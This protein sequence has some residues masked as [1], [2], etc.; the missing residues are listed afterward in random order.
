[1][2]IPQSWHSDVKRWGVIGRVHILLMDKLRR[3]LIIFGVYVRPI[4][5]DAPVPKAPD[6]LLVRAAHEEELRQAAKDPELD[7]S[8]DFVNAALARGDLCTAAFDGARIVAYIW[9]SFATAPHVDGLWVRF[10]PGYRYGY[11][12][13]TLPAYRGRHLPACMAT[14]LDRYSVE[15]GVTRTIGSIETHNYPSIASELRRGS[16]RVGWAGYFKLFGRTYPF[17]TPGAKRSGFALFKD[18]QSSPAT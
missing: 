1:M 6:G 7:L 11:K 4:H 3:W 18:E 2:L 17:R 13:F 12:L 9:R 14:Y 5:A 8:E 15:R 10:G 16:H